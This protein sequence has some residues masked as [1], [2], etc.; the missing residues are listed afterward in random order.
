[1]RGPPPYAMTVVLNA[2]AA[3]TTRASARTEPTIIQ[4]PS[5]TRPRARFTAARR[6]RVK[7]RTYTMV[8]A[9]GYRVTCSAW[10]DHCCQPPSTPTTERRIVC[11]NAATSIAAIEPLKRVTALSLSPKA[12]NRKLA[13]AEPR[14]AAQA[15]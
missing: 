6:R 15:S 3:K 14:A 5:S 4:P 2:W 13:P 8:P 12:M 9:P 11:P 10:A 7:A 1:S